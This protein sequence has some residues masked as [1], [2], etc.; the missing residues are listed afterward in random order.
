MANDI[1]DIIESTESQ[2]D[3]ILKY[4]DKYGYITA[5]EAISY[6]NC[7]RLSARIVDL[8]SKG[9]VFDH[10]MFYYKDNKG[11]TRRFMKYWLVVKK[12]S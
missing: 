10:Q 7:F 12:V 1:D 11:K 9:N 6:L 3:E 8:E 2:C 5:K 4:C